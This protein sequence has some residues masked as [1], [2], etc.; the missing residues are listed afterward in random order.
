MT[1][2]S[3]YLDSVSLRARNADGLELDNI[4]RSALAALRA[5][6]MRHT[7]ELGST[8]DDDGAIVDWHH[9]AADMHDWPCL[10]ITAINDA[11][12]GDS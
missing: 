5:V 4:A 12:G 1:D 2:T 11:L 10:T 3:D 7:K 9:C 8:F 6:V